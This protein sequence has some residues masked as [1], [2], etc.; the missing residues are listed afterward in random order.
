[1]SPVNMQASTVRV[2]GRPAAARVGGT[3]LAGRKAFNGQAANSHKLAGVSSRRQ[4][5]AA[6]A[7]RDGEKLD[8]K[9]RVAVVGGGPAGACTADE[10]AKGGCETYMIERKLDNC[11]V[12]R[13]THCSP[14]STRSSYA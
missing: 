2:A 3:R 12:R 5:V 13:A 8:R 9:L 1:M 7:I 14:E 10:L 6:Q 4:T 11:K